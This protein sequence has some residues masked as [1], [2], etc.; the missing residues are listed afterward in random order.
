MKFT[1][2]CKTTQQNAK[3]VFQQNLSKYG[4]IDF[5]FGFDKQAKNNFTS[6]V[7]YSSYY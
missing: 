3:R 2:L 7:E 5:A 6:L 4:K 1:A